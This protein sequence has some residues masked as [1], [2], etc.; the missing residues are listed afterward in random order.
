MEL[1]PKQIFRKMLGG[2]RDGD[3]ILIGEGVTSVT[4]ELWNGEYRIDKDGNFYLEMERMKLVRNIL[5]SFGR[6]IWLAI[7][8]EEVLVS[9]DARNIRLAICKKVSF[10]SSKSL[11]PLWLLFIYQKSAFF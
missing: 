10:Y 7:S 4:N 1:E 11:Y 3:D 8:G 6:T 9:Q 5:T 2:P